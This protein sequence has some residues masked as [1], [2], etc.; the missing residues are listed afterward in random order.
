MILKSIVMR[1]FK[2]FFNET[3]LEFLDRKI[4]VVGPNGCGK[5]NILDAI[6]W[7]TG[8]MSAKSL[9]SSTLTDVI[10]DGTET[11][12]PAAMAEITLKFDNSSKILPITSDEVEITRKIYR[13]GE[14]EYFIN[15][16]PC[17]LKDIKE[18]FLDTG[19]GYNGYSFIEQAGVE[20]VIMAKPQERREL[21]EEASGIAKFRVKEE[22]TLRKLEKVEFD[23]VRLNDHISMLKE[24]IK[25]LE[26]SVNKAKLFN[27]YNDEIKR[28][29]ISNLLFHHQQLQSQFKIFND[30]FENKNAIFLSLKTEREKIDLE[31]SNFKLE[32][33]KIEKEYLGLIQ[34]IGEYD[35][36]LLLTEEKI[37]SSRRLIEEY[38]NQHKKNETDIILETENLIKLQKEKTQLEETLKSLNF[39][40]SEAKLK[41]IDGNLNDIQ[42]KINSLQNELKDKDD[43][44][45]KNTS[46]KVSLNNE[47]LNMSSKISRL[48]TEIENFN[49]EKTE[50]ER[51]LEK[52]K[53]EF[54]NLQEVIK[55]NQNQSHNLKSQIE[56]LQNERNQ[57]SDT[58]KK[59]EDEI[60]ITQKEITTLQAYK[61][62]LKKIEELDL[63][64]SGTNY[65]L[66]LGLD[67]IYGT[68]GQT[69]K[70][71]SE[72]QNLIREFLG[73]KINWIVCAT[74]D[75]AEKSINYLKEAGKGRAAFIVMET[76]KNHQ[77]KEFISDENILSLKNMIDVEPQLQPLVNFLFSN[78]YYSNNTIYSKGI[79]IG[80]CDIKESIFFY[81]LPEL[82]EKIAD[83]QDKLTQL[84]FNR[85]NLDLK[86]K[87]IDIEYSNINKNLVSIETYKEVLAQKKAELETEI[88]L[89]TEK[90]D[91]V[92]KEISLKTIEEKEITNKKN[93]IIENIKQLEEEEKNFNSSKNEI[94][95]ML[96]DL[97]KQKQ[98]LNHI[99]ITTDYEIKRQR[100]NYNSIITKIEESDK[101]I[102]YIKNQIDSKTAENNYLSKKIEE[103]KN[104]I[105]ENENSIN[106]IF[107]DKEQLLKI[108]EEK[109]NCKE[110]LH[111]K[112]QE[113]ENLIKDKF[114]E[115]LNLESEVDNSKSS[116]QQQKIKI[117]N[118]VEKL[119]LNYS[120]N[121]ED[122]LKV[123]T[124]EEIPEEK[125][126]F[127]KRKR[128]RI[129][130][131][132]PAAP[133][134]YELLMQRYNFL[135]TQKED[136]EKAK[137]NLKNTINKINKTT[138][139]E[140]LNGFENIRKNFKE[141]F[142]SLFNG[143]KCDIV[144]TNP[145]NLLETGIEIFAQPPG[146][147]LQS[148]SLLSGG[149]KSLTA[150]ALLFAFFKTK[151]S[152]ICILDEADAALDEA[153]T[154]KFVNLINEFAKT[155]QFV[156]ITHNKRTMEISDKIYGITM[157]TPG[158]S[159]L[160]SVNLVQAK[161]LAEVR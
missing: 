109:F 98:E 146:K 88:N 6:K 63:L 65:I 96:E 52:K 101:T 104:S 155:T 56:N 97:N 20:W 144:L 73:P 28:L 66:E 115:L 91:V 29:E 64:L 17:R 145:E 142:Q 102:K 57:I 92:M 81:S 21:F 90:F 45:F 22:E 70:I 118:I 140:F 149:E 87:Q 10:F 95:K 1:G 132:N 106:Q 19:F 103:E 86:L 49:K 75:V 111:K 122:A 137:Q 68:V 116:L 74:V 136:L 13:S 25:S 141:I 128:E 37:S 33:V 85:E 100:E 112:I 154:I 131:V 121:I 138:K 157:E 71:K 77:E 9:R 93:T 110:N 123:F 153:N 36:N 24:Q 67:G 156:I 69:L 42:E 2:S 120:L 78:S 8:E 133:E 151:K 119:K 14:A 130:V 3:V 143:G 30:D 127:L 134:E 15:N 94:L 126:E 108:S 55:N 50:F 40:D 125:I 48:S 41:Q 12:L 54:N 62:A 150:L 80:G 139:E 39:K 34:R 160:L 53:N 23:M 158:I 47:L 18:L 5:S 31:L 99:Y 147:K 117:E 58:V 51:E 61:D 105:S 11:E 84:N 7:A 76:I 124:P 38:R 148:I 44:I 16:Q 82:D 159:K 32:F 79:V 43:N 59:L 26:Q 4:V 114:E 113:Y 107:K 129:G 161:E 135:M 60:I 83:C 89:L 46:L 27:Q 72:Y 35:K 152:S